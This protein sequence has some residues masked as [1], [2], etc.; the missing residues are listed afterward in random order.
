[1]LHL[2]WKLF[3]EEGE[4]VP[5][6]CRKDCHLGLCDTVMTTLHPLSEQSLARFSVSSML[7]F[8]E[9]ATVS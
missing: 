5:L 4:L 8:V 7:Y 9:N 2:T 3:C 1:M 6:V